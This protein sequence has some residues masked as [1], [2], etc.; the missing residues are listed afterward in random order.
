M[1]STPPATALPNYTNR[2]NTLCND[3]QFEEALRTHSE[4]LRQGRHTGMGAG[5]ERHRYGLSPH[6]LTGDVKLRISTMLPSRDNDMTTAW[7]SCDHG[8]VIP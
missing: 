3:S 6:G 2:G 5:T 8:V 1:S 4:G 7:S